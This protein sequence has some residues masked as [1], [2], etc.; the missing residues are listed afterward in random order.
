VILN[1]T[2]SITEMARKYM[3]FFVEESCGYCTPC[4]VG[5]ALLKKMLEDILDGNGQ[6]SDIDYLHDLAET[7][8]T[9][10]RCG[11]GQASPN[12]ILTT[13]E[14][15]R[16]VYEALLKENPKQRA[17]AFDIGE[18]LAASE[19]L[20]GANRS[21]I[22][23]EKAHER[24]DQHHDRWSDHTGPE[25]TN[26]FGSGL[27]AGIYIPHLCAYPGLSPTDPAGFARSWQTER[28]QTALHNAGHGR[29]G[30]PERH[31]GTEKNPREHHRDAVCRRQ[32][33]LHVL[34]KE[35]KLRIA[36]HGVSV[37]HHRAAFPLSGA[38]TG[39]GCHAPGHP[40]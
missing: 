16:P 23:P 13:L 26:H 7:V 18:A 10:S 34:R 29:H 2:R 33:F 8:K 35:R 19:E 28:P 15:F 27:G 5:N 37:R 30:D 3:D 4:R 36:G 24:N 9:A 1:S 25:G 17:P 20:T 31:P 22:Q 6:P 12:P 21:C 32:P 11:L 39:G 14:R 40:H 38:Q